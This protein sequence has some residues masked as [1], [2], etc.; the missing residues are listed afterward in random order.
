MSK[1][2]RRMFF[3]ALCQLRQRYANRDAD[4]ASS[5]ISVADAM[6]L[7]NGLLEMAPRAMSPE[8]ES[9]Q[10]DAETR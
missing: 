7:A 9:V 1:Y 6:A 5:C 4:D 10:A 2:E 3:E 8:T